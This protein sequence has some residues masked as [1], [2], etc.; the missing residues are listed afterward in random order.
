MAKLINLVGQNDA[1]T[2]NTKYGYSADLVV[3]RNPS[4]GSIAV[5][6]NTG[7][8]TNDVAV[9]GPTANG[10]DQSAAFGAGA[11]IHFYFIWNG[12]TLA[13]L[14][15]LTAPPTGPTLPTGYTHWAYVTTIG[16]PA[17]ALR[18]TK[19]EGSRTIY[20]EALVALSGGTATTQTSISTSGWIP[21]NALRQDLLAQLQA[22]GITTTGTDTADFLITGGSA[23][24]SRV[25]LIGNTTF[26]N[27]SSGEFTFPLNGQ[28]FIYQITRGSVGGTVSVDV[29]VRGY[30]IPNGGE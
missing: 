23:F 14:S 27:V 3:L 9:S 2:P 11:W 15:S 21:P 16:F 24:T 6:T 5:R 25:L 30:S 7:T 12:S 18:Q 4:D 17:S 19:V 22:T 10:R 13:S 20:R 29:Y 1:T 8:F 28:T 26:A